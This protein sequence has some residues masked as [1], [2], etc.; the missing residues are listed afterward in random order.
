MFSVYTKCRESIYRLWL[1]ILVF[2]R[3]KNIIIF[4]NTFT[5]MIEKL[6]TTGIVRAVYFSLGNTPSKDPD[7]SC[8]KAVRNLIGEARESIKIAIYS[9]SE[10]EIISS[11]AEAKKRVK[12]ILVIAD[13]SQSKGK[14]MSH[15]LETLRGAGIDVRVAKRQKAL[16]H[17]KV[18]IV[19]GKIVAT[20]S[21]NYTL[22]AYHND[23]NL[24]ILQGEELAGMYQKYVF[25][26]ILQNETLYKL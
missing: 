7:L 3:E 15:A 25:D 13:L 10:P 14:A 8:A 21:Y 9:I 26:R 6:S 5:I 16:M 11:L 18:M 19:D 17:N 12:D 24:I 4:L 23:E 20:G 22:H 1:W 2:K